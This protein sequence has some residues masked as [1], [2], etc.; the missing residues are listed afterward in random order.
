MKKHITWLMTVGVLV[1][2]CGGSTGSAFEPAD[3]GEALL[4]TAA[5]ETTIAGA[6]LDEDESGRD[7]GVPT[8]SDRKVIYD[9]HMQLQAADTRAVFDQITVM[10]QAE[11]GFVA[12]AVV[13]ETEEAE[14]QPNI[15]V[16]VRLPADRLTGTLSKI[17]SLADRVVSESL[18]TQDVTDQFVDIEAQLR[19][20]YALE[21]ELLALLAELRDN[22]DAD[23]AKLLQV[24]DQIRQT[25]GEIEQLEG[26]RQLLENLV[27]LATLDIGIAPLPA[28]A[29]IVP[30]PAW[31]PAT[32]ARSALRDTVVAFQRLAETLIRFGLNVLPVLIVTLGPFVLA[33]WFFYRRW[34][35]RTPAES[36][37]L[38]AGS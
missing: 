16:V 5:P 28:A 3:G 34:R 9:G 15:S 12:S 26:R 7:L 13:E 38:A 14:D 31:E 32:V 4:T 19:N 21:T 11:G 25:R 27:A 29:P 23:P 36:S 22:Q 18:S 2:A 33:G 24:F 6:A 8:A 30:E 17:R 10:A 37:T 35:R 20:L 1:A